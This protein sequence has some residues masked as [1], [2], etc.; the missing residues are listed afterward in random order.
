MVPR[1]GRPV[2]CGAARGTTTPTTP[3][4]RFG[5]TPSLLTSTAPTG[6]GVQGGF[7]FCSFA[8]SAWAQSLAT[9]PRLS[10]QPV[11]AP[12]CLLNQNAC[13]GVLARILDKCPVSANLARGEGDCSRRLVGGAFWGS[14]NGEFGSF[15][16]AFC[17]LWLQTVVSGRV[18]SYVW[19]GKIGRA[20]DDV[21]CWRVRPGYEIIGHLDCDPRLR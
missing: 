6:F 12:H 9:A 11:A 10:R 4:A 7:K 15:S 17:V 21:Q 1:Q 20:T 8:R 14:A 18:F 13:K 5:A 16:E 19:V 3:G 2:S